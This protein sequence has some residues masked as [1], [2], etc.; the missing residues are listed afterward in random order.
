MV[1]KDVNLMRGYRIVRKALQFLQLKGCIAAMT[2]FTNFAALEATPDW[3]SFQ[4]YL[5]KDIMILDNPADRI[6]IISL[7]FLSLFIVHLRC[8][9]CL[10]SPPTNFYHALRVTSTTLKQLSYCLEVFTNLKSFLAYQATCTSTLTG[11][12][13][14]F[15][16]KLTS[17]L[18]DYTFRVSVISSLF[19][20]AEPVL[21]CKLLFL[22]AQP[23]ECAIKLTLCDPESLL[24]LCLRYNNYSLGKSVANFLNIRES[25]IYRSSLEEQLSKIVVGPE[26]ISQTGILLIK[27]LVITQSGSIMQQLVS[28]GHDSMARSVCID[29]A[30]NSTNSASALAILGLTD[31]LPV[32]AIL[33][34]QK[35]K[36]RVGKYSILIFKV[37]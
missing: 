24:C 32:G 27:E 16:Q 35:E 23:I 1:S 11:E 25:I 12:I 37:G 6:V 9:H 13:G 30:I 22:T 34:P 26:S 18:K 19:K 2:P 14:S 20:T 29:L 5:D 21:L 31:M 8:C 28:E 17:Y 15:S 33:T 3:P 10:E 7:I 4:S 36:V